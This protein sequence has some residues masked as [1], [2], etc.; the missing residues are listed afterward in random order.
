MAVIGVTCRSKI[1]K[2]VA[3]GNGGNLENLFFSSSSEPKSLINSN[4]GTKKLV[5]CRLNVIKIVSIG[6]PNGRHG[7]HLENLF[8]AS[9]P[10][11]KD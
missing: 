7:H 3:I 6:N 11:P 9:S 4:L 8:F 5:T 2:I 10:E 1:A